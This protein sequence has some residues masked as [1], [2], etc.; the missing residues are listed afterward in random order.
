MPLTFCCVNISL[1]K[2]L[3][4]YFP[5]KLLCQYFP[6]KLL[7]QYFPLKLLCQYFPLELLCQYSPPTLQGKGDPKD[8]E[9]RVQQ[10][11]DDIELSTS[12]YEKE[13]MNERLAKLSNGIAVL[14]V[15]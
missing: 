7:C 6:L 3:C 5:L 4:Q 15:Y 14:K 10:I 12:E 13:K 8:I 11:R 9:K 1:L 2:L